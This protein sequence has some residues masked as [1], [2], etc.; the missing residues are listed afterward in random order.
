LFCPGADDLIELAVSRSM[1]G[2]ADAADGASGVLLVAS[3]S[4]MVQPSSPD[5]RDRQHACRRW[6]ARPQQVIVNRGNLE[7]A[8]DELRHDRIDLGFSSTRS[9]ITM[10][11]PCIGMNAIQPPSANVGLMVTPSSATVRS[12]R[13]NP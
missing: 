10:A 9:P 8:R 2:A 13:G 4:R 11:S 1:A 5:R 6:Q 12:L 3:A 7:P